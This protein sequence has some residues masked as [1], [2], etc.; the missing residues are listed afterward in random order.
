MC[1]FSKG[2]K[3]GLVLSDFFGVGVISGLMLAA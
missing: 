3:F 1:P 2:A